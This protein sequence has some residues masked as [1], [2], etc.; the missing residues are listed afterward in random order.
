MWTSSAAN[1]ACARPA[2]RRDSNLRR[3]PASAFFFLLAALL[4][5]SAAGAVRAG[6]AQCRTTRFDSVGTV[7]Y[8]V[9][10]DTVWLTDGRKVRLIGIDTPE[11]GHEGRRSEP[12]ARKARRALQGLLAAHHRRVGLVHDREAHDHYGRTLAHVF[13]R[14]G[15][16][17][18]ASLLDAGLGTGFAVPPDLRF[19]DCYRA[20][21]QRARAARRGIWSL[22]RY[23]PR[24]V[25]TLRPGMEGYRVIDGEVRGIGHS[26][27]ALWLEF[28]ARFAVR[29]PRSDLVY[30]KAYD[31]ARLAGERVRV[32]GKVF[33]SHGQLRLELRHPADLQILGATARP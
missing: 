24:A 22:A 5:L 9:D 27:T 7:R 20:A 25:R 13:L 19:L 28:G 21:E 12:Y 29:I 1:T 6:T 31:P 15:T 4:C 16:S 2:S 11:I 17:V 8:V 10:G 32:R 33:R 14:D 3:S 30:F 18:E 26:R 23:Q